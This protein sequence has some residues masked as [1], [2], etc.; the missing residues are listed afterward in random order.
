MSI[1]TSPLFTEASGTLG[2]FIIYK[3]RGQIRMRSKPGAYSDKKAPGR[4]HSGRNSKIAFTFIAY[5][6]AFL[7]VPG[8]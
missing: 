1:I 5:S 6:I 8:A 4:F 2:N 3:V 7:S